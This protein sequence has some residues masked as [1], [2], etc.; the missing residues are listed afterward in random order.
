MLKKLISVVLCLFPVT[1]IAATV[2]DI[3]ATDKDASVSVDSVWDDAVSAGNTIRISTGAGINAGTGLDINGIVQVGTPSNAGLGTSNNLYVM[4][5]DN[6]ATDFVISTGGDVSIGTLLQVLNAYNLEVS[7]MSGTNANFSVGAIEVGSNQSA[8]KLSI[9]GFDNLQSTGTITTYGDLDVNVGAMTTGSMNLFAGNTDIDVTNGD[10][11]VNGDIAKLSAGEVDIISSQHIKIT[12]NL[13]N[14]SGQMDLSAGD[15]ISVGGSFENLGDMRVKAKNLVV[16]GTM[17]NTGDGLVLQ[18]LTSWTVNGTDSG[19]SFVNYADLVANV[20]GKTKFAGGIDISDMVNTGTFSLTTGQMVFG[21]NNAILNHL[22]NFVLNVTDGDL[23]LSSLSNVASD[24]NLDL[25]VSG[26]LTINN[27]VNNGGV[28]DVVAGAFS[29]DGMVN[30]VAENALSAA[31]GTTTSIVSGGVI[32]ITA[33]ISNSGNMTLKSPQVNLVSVVNSGENSK[34]Q[35]GALTDQT[36]AI[37]VSGDVTTYGGTTSL[38]AKDVSVS[39]GLINNGGDLYIKASDHNGGAV[40]VGAISALKQGG[41]IDINASAGALDVSGTI[42]VTNGQLN[43]GADIFDLSVAGNVQLNGDFYANSASVLN[44]GDM[45]IGASGNTAFKVSADSILIGGDVVVGEVATNR[46]VVFDAPVYVGGDIVVQNNAMLNLGLAATDSV[47]VKGAVNVDASSVLISN[48]EIFNTGSVQADG[49]MKMYGQ[50]LMA[51]TGNIEINGDIRFF[52]EMTDNSGLEILDANNSNY[53]IKALASGADVSVENIIVQNVAGVGQNLDIQSAGDVY[54]S[55]T[56]S[57]NGVLNITATDSVVVDGAVESAN[58]LNISAD[59]IKT[60]KLN[61]QAG[62]VGVFANTSVN[63]GDIENTAAAITVAASDGVSATDKV[64]VG[65]VLHNGGSISIVAD[66]FLADGLVVN[67]SGVTLN[68]GVIDVAADI[69]VDGKLTQG[70]QTGALNLLNTTELYAN[71]MDVTAGLDLTVGNVLYDI[72][73]TVAVGG[74]ILVANGVIAEFIAGN[75]FG[76]QNLTNNADFTVSA[77]GI[78]LAGV[79]NNSGNLSFDSGKSDLDVAFLQVNN[80][81]VYLDGASLQSD[82]AF[83]A[84]GGLYQ[85]L[86]T[87]ITGGDVYVKNQNYFIDATNV[88]VSDIKQSGRMQIVSGDVTVA[89]DIDAEDLSFVAGNSADGWMYADIGGNVSGGVDFIGLKKLHIGGNYTFNNNS[90]L[91]VALLPYAAGMVPNTADVN[92]WSTVSVNNDNTLGQ[93]TNPAGAGALI[94]IDGSFISNLSLND[95]S[96]VTSG[97]L[98]NSQIGISVFDMIDEGTAVWLLAAKQGITELDGK[99]RNIDVKFCNE[100]GSICVDYFDKDE[101]NNKS[102]TDLPAYVSV[103]DMLSNDGVSDSL[104][105]VFDSRFGGPVEIFGLQPIVGREVGH[106]YGEYVSAGALD[107]LIANQVKRNKFYN[108]TPI[109]VIPEIFKNTNL[110]NAANELYLR[111]EDYVTNRNGAPLTA[112]SRLFQTHEL[113]QIAGAISLNEHTAFRSFEDRMVDE[114]I[115]NRN[116]NLQKAWLDVDYG[117]SYQNMNA[118]GHADGYRFSMAGGF[119]WQESNTL[120][121]GFTGRI[122][123]TSSSSH[124]AVNLGYSNVSEHGAVSV[125][126]ADTNI[127]LGGY[128]MKTLHEKLRL[129]GNAFLDAHILDVN[130]SQNFVNSI[131]G[132]GSS[133]SLISEWGLLHDILNQYIV[134]NFYARTGYNFGFNVKESAA[135]SEYMRMESDG[136]LILTPGYSLTAQKRIY[137]SA[138]FQMRPYASVGIEYDLLGAPDT[139]N[140]KFALADKYTS[141]DIDVNPMWANIGG[142][143]EFLSARGVQFGIDYR[144]QYNNDIQLHNIKMSGSYRF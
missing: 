68:A 53:Q 109:E 25:D 73:Q 143:I 48:S 91:N 129:Y 33:G 134:G 15:T 97:V 132:D 82:G 14:N 65:N 127:A 21:T 74:D 4:Q 107:N 98:E 26:Q 7:I 80:G 71:N 23:L 20:S 137:P 114:F 121:L 32:D 61:A 6:V 96:G 63:L 85:G 116:R 140:Y 11:V 86:N 64:V 87:N 16:D 58:R 59:S 22:Q 38:W 122:A 115:W 112:F 36:G 101:A 60:G 47:T 34:L 110:S 43:L 83:A 28:I 72:D 84:T 117:M 99:I 144:Y 62:M 49:K 75:S 104:Y 2:V 40:S 29:A 133:F 41:L 1:S 120:I 19:Y 81:V 138:W 10:L 17:N 56:I 54:A 51:D 12:G 139:A 37:S 39:G 13:Q 24:A 30:G 119:D 46:N 5:S 125:E 42:S 130:R 70:A 50:S 69:Y 3:N 128:M 113:E 31:T 106:T 77:N 108:R 100:D 93:I 141:Y 131:D 18:G 78:K 52:E 142:G 88:S 111:M 102:D 105:I 44:S 27:L 90:S 94:S 79:T 95:M 9:L 92:Y 76:A 35:I 55:G 8:A 135:G 45:K 118:G 67:A 57:N 103:R 124:D 123:H 66:N 126:V 136:Y 89:G